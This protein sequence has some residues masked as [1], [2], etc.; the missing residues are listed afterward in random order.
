MSKWE[1]SHPGSAVTNPTSIHEDSGSI[2][3][4]AQWAK[5]S[6][7]AVNYGVGCRCSSDLV[8]LHL[9]CRWAAAALIQ[10]LAWEPLYALK[11]SPKRQKQKQD[12]QR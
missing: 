2:P 4:P 12:V 9:W 8:L 7:I 1:H 11:D 6:V 5:G 3:G 10:P